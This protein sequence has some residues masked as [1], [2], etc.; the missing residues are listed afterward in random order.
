MR[1][2]LKNI[3]GEFKLWICNH[4]VCK[5]PSHTFRLFFYRKIMRFKIGKGSSIHLGCFFNVKENLIIGD[6]STINMRCHLDNRGGIFIGN[7]VSISPYVSLITA[8]HD[9]QLSDFSGRVSKIVL[10]DYVFIGYRSLILKNIIMEKGSVLSAGSVLT[11]DTEQFTI[12]AGVPALKIK[13]R[14]MN[15]NYSTK[16]KRL[17]W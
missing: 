15:L 11:K 5:V 3:L 9:I 16:Y 10:N 13:S 8:D 17:F 2:T 1:Y 4:V 6:N 7:N 14:N 12:Y